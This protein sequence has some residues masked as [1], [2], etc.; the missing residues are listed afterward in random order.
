MLLASDGCAYIAEGLEV[1]EAADVVA[2]GEAWD[3]FARVLEKAAQQVV[4][5][6]DIERCGLAREDVNEVGLHR[7]GRYGGILIRGLRFVSRGD[8]RGDAGE[9]VLLAKVEA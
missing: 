9:A 4:C 6:A 1:D 2:A 5:D 8:E 3:E 7:G